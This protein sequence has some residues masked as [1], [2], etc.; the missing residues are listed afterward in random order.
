MKTNP[1]ARK[2]PLPSTPKCPH[3]GSQHFNTS[4]FM[5]QCINCTYTEYAT[6]AISPSTPTHTTSLPQVEKVVRR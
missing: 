3:C 4:P 6:I 2:L 5:R 1:A